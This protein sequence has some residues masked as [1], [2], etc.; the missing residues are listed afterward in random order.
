M[1]RLLLAF[2]LLTSVFPVFGEASLYTSNEFGM[3]LRPVEPYRRD[4]SRWILEV[5]TTGKDEVRRLYDHGREAR[6]WEISW[7]ENGTRKVEREL[8]GGVLSARRLYDGAGGLLQEDLYDNGTLTQKTAL[9]YAGGRL[10]RV[11]VQTG[12][13]L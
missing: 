12:D 2:L 7:T 1:R 3:I 11:R 13:G 5:S 8:A 4:E 10:T 6:R 9:T